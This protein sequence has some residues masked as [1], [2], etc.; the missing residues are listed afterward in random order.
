MVVGF[1]CQKRLTGTF[2]GRDKPS[3]RLEGHQVRAPAGNDAPKQPQQGRFINWIHGTAEAGK[4]AS[5]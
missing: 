2:C 1:S 5:F 4:L 3:S